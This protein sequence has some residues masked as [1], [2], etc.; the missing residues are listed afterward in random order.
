MAANVLI[1]VSEYLSTS[2]SPDCDYVDGE[3]Q[4]R[5]MGETDHGEL[6]G[7]LLE[8]LR[9]PANK[10]YF[11]T[12]P[13]VRVQVAPTRFRVP[14]VCLRRITAQKE[15]IVVTPPLLCIEVLSPEDTMR[16]TRQRVRDFLSMGVLE[17][18]IVDPA[19]RSISV[20]TGSTMV[21][22]SAGALTMPGTPVV[23]ELAEVFQVLDES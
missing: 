3:V 4:E 17:V 22:N 9:T 6:Q 19:A 16:K 18:W 23:L 13:E 10:A 7:Q 14:D 15:Q 1:P 12:I 8:L 5:N 21:E 20:C 2:Y 11:R